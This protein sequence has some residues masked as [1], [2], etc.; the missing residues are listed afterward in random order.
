[1]GAVPWSHF[2]GIWAQ[3]RGRSLSV[4]ETL[5]VLAWI[6]R[7]TGVAWCVPSGADH[8]LGVHIPLHSTTA[9]HPASLVQHGQYLTIN[10]SC[11]CGGKGPAVG[12]VST[13]THKGPRFLWAGTGGM[14]LQLLRLSRLIY[15]R[16][17]YYSTIIPIY[18]ENYFIYPRRF[19][20]FLHTRD[21]IILRLYLTTL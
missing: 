16:Q 17:L 12:Y 19:P 15:L 5:S 13:R 20:L 8:F 11:G 7:K 3:S 10:W 4:V 1:M 9:R 14:R 21:K 2:A 6:V 18:Y